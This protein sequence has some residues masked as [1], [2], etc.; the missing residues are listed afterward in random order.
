MNEKIEIYGYDSEFANIVMAM[1][2]TKLLNLSKY[3][4][5]KKQDML[6]FN[7]DVKKGTLIINPPYGERLSDLDSVNTLYKM[8]GDVFKNKC[9]GFNCLVFTSNLD[10][11]KNIGL[12]ANKKIVLKN[13]SLDSRLLFY[14]IQKGNYEK[15]IEEQKSSSI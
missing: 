14:P 15:K 3:I 5:F 1:Y 10:A 9:V 2:S 6:N 4:K 11:A 12:Q 7:T 13:G 8:I